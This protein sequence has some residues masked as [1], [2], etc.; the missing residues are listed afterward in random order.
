MLALSLLLGQTT[1]PRVDLR[2]VV[3]YE[4]NLRA[5]QPGKPFVELREELSSIRRLGANVLWLMPIHPVGQLRSV[6][7]LGSPYAV[8]DYQ[9]LNPEFGTEAEFRSLLGEAKRLGMRVILDWVA[10]HTSWDHPWILNPGW[11][12]V[13]AQGNIIIPP[14]TNW[15][16]VAEL[17][18]DNAAMRQEMLASMRYWIETYGVDGFRCDHVDGVPD[19]FWQS[20][21]SSLRTQFADRRLLFLGEAS[22]ANLVPTVGFDLLYDWDTFSFLK[23]IFAGTRSAKDFVPQAR[24]ST[25]PRMRF[26]TNHDESAWNGGLASTSGTAE[27]AAAAFQALVFSGG[28]PMIYSSQEI[29]Y[30]A[31]LPFFSATTVNWSSGASA[32]AD[33]SRVMSDFSRLKMPMRPTLQDASTTRVILYRAQGA[34][35]SIVVAVN[36]S[37]D[38][39]P[40]SI[41]STWGV[42]TPPSTIAGHRALR[43]M[44][45]QRGQRAEPTE[46]PG[47]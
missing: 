22:R 41:P 36:S 5:F 42:R 3:V 4:A 1:P 44:Q 19:S 33:L 40:L 35:G 21:L 18:Y 11:H 25:V 13:D 14:G 7:Q 10:N 8:R 31:A 26:I 29:G 17:N 2:N 30:G 32:R 47:R 37:P 27:G 20:A 23:Q 24:R 43:F 46:V 34:A 6:G 16:D 45:P 15:N 28:V 38:P 9:G 39:Q 12:S